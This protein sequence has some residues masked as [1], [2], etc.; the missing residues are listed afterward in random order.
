MG[1][2]IVLN[3]AEKP[4]EMKEF[5]IERESDESLGLEVSLS[6]NGPYRFIISKVRLFVTVLTITIRF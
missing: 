6:Y 1:V 5:I 3:A 4:M 2:Q